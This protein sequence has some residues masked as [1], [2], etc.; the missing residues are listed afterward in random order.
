[1]ASSFSIF[2]IK[3]TQ[4]VDTG[5][6]EKLVNKDQN[7]GYPAL[8]ENGNLLI[9]GNTLA[10][11]W[12]VGSNLAFINRDTGEWGLWF[13]HSDQGT[14]TPYTLKNGS[15]QE[16]ATKPVACWDLKLGTGRITGT[17]SGVNSYYFSLG[18]EF[19]FFPNIQGKLSGG[20]EGYLMY[21]WTNSEYGDQVGRFGWRNTTGLEFTY[22]WR[23]RYI[24]ASL[25]ALIVIYDNN[26]VVT[27]SE[28]DREETIR[29]E[30][31]EVRDDKGRKINM[32]KEIIYPVT[33]DNI[34]T[35]INQ[36][37]N[38]SIDVTPLKKDLEEIMKY[39]EQRKIQW[40]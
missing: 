31:I 37:K 1:M 38:I 39:K 40:E 9:K 17:V 27:L 10:I 22:W 15:P 2:Q 20:N 19:A 12:N 34:D 21:Y 36:L 33:M 6:F 8:D 32:K 7:N 25:P 30:F 11:S 28:V 14:Y 13:Y 3:D 29:T 24:T 26:H 23:W 16:F 35:I 5:R 18:T 4:I